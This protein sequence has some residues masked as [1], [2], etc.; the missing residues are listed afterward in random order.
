MFQIPECCVATNEQMS[1]NEC[2]QKEE[3]K[4][5]HEL[6]KKALSECERRVNYDRKKRFSYQN[7][8]RALKKRRKKISYSRACDVL[9]K[10]FQS[11]RRK[12]IT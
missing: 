11:G 7:Y 6:I 8:Y 10:I 5:D 12:Q 1:S 4:R 9:V 2:I 3:P